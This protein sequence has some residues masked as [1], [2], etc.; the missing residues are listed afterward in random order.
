[1]SL[2]TTGNHILGHG[3]FK[4]SAL[5]QALLAA[6]ASRLRQFDAN[7]IDLQLDEPMER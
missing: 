7:F 5:G 4:L 1:M 3:R 2:Q 6:P